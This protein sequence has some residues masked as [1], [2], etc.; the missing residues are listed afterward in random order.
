MKLNK[1][2]FIKSKALLRAMVSL[3]MLSTL[4]TLTTFTNLASASANESF[5]ISQVDEFSIIKSTALR[6]ARQDATQPNLVE[7]GPIVLSGDYALASWLYGEMG[8][9]VLLKKE[10][11][12]WRVITGGGGSLEDVNYLMQQGVPRENAEGLAEGA[13]V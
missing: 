1:N 7:I 9:Q 5:K 11:K 4:P 8:G 10:N 12:Q 2:K 3:T 13:D 6:W